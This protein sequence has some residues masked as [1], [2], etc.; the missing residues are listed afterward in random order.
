MAS[1]SSDGKGVA[2]QAPAIFIGGKFYLFLGCGMTFDSDKKRV[3]PAVQLLDTQKKCPVV[4]DG[5][6]AIKI[7]RQFYPVARH[8]AGRGLLIM[9]PAYPASHK[10]LELRP[11]TAR[12]EAMNELFFGTVFTAAP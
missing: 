2:D 10:T 4:L 8:D 7:I 6:I 9:E 5:V 12:Y 3:L 1:A 11:G